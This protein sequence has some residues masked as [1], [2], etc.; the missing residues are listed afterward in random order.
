[1][2]VQQVTGPGRAAARAGSLILA[3]AAGLSS[4]LWVA[5]CAAAPEFIWRG[6]KITLGHLDVGDVLSALLIGLVLAFFVEPLMRRL[7]A[8]VEGERGTSGAS[9]R[10][11]NALFAASMGFVFAF[12]S[13]CVHDAMI[14]FVA[15]GDGGHAGEAS[16]V[17]AGIALTATWAIV[18]FATTL[19]WVSARSRWLRLP[20]GAIAAVSAALS[21]WLFGWTLF[22]IVSSVIPCLAILALGYREIGRDPLEEAF[23]RAGRRLVL[24]AAVWLV[25]AAIVCAL[26]GLIGASPAMLYSPSSFWMD[27]RFYL[28]W[29]IGLLLAPFPVA[30]AASARATA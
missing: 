7:Q 29:A 14:A 9:P 22:E 17:A 27:A 21:G 24:V 26:L 8:R 13:V 2:T 6:L 12:A 18:P 28:G 19:A 4:A 3:I 15:G 16:G 30:A 5:I 25:S 10:P 23:V 1:M 11:R 20:M